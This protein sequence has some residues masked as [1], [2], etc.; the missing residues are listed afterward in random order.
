VLL[1]LALAAC[2]DDK[3]SPAAAPQPDSP[4]ALASAGGAPVTAADGTRFAPDWLV[5][6]DSTPV[7]TVF[8]TSGPDLDGDRVEVGSTAIGRVT[9]R[10]ATGEV[11]SRQ[12]VVG[13]LD[14]PS[15]DPVEEVPPIRVG[16]AEIADQRL[17]VGA[18]E[19][20]GR[21]VQRQGAL[22]QIGASTVVALRVS[23][24]DGAGPIIEPVWI[25]VD[26]GTIASA[27]AGT[28]GAGV[29]A[30]DI[31]P[32]GVA[33]VIRFGRDLERHQVA[34][35]GP[36][37]AL[38]WRWDLPAPQKARVDLSVAVGDQAVFVF[39]D[40]R[41]L[42]RLPLESPTPAAGSADAAT[43]VLENPTP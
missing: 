26:R 38:R 10:A 11:L 12:P 19:V 28:T 21:F 33:A 1:A 2:G 23:P 25:D 40:G 22:G 8:R 9:V 20:P 32:A 30:A 31:A 41:D 43:P 24:A 15:D 35:W 16:P 7:I 34:F 27:G 14:L 3:A 29:V 6:L 17:H 4:V 5:R 42:A 18:V 13:P 39:Y 37:G 36:D